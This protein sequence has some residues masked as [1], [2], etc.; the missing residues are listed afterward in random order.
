[1][2]PC[3]RIAERESKYVKNEKC[4]VV[5][6]NVWKNIVKREIKMT[7]DILVA[8]KGRVP[9]NDRQRDLA[10]DRGRVAL[11]ILTIRVALFQVL[12]TMERGAV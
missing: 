6:R 9:I 4:V 12:E 3:R 2:S 5:V 7:V 1:L 10:E 8:K 11:L